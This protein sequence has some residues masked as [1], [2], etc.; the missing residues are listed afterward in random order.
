MAQYSS[1]CIFNIFAD[2]EVDL[3]LSRDAIYFSLSLPHSFSHS[4]SLS[5]SVSLQRQHHFLLLPLPPFVQILV[6]YIYKF[7]TTSSLECNY[8]SIFFLPFPYSRS[9]FTSVCVCLCVLNAKI[10]YFN[11]EVWKV[12]LVAPCLALPHLI[13]FRFVRFKKQKF[14]IISHEVYH[15]LQQLQLLLHLLLLLIFLTQHLLFATFSWLVFILAQ[16]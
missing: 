4:L 11:I 14:A 9:Q 16:K 7:L 5:H 1:N 10:A 15:F 13:S 3:L 2:T 6:L 12:R 8:F